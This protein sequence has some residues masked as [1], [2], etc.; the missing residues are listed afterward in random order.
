M[1][2]VGGSPNCTTKSPLL[3]KGNCWIHMLHGLDSSM[4]ACC[5]IPP[6]HH[7]PS[8]GIV[9]MCHGISPRPHMAKAAAEATTAAT[10]EAAAETT[11]PKKSPPTAMAARVGVAWQQL[12]RQGQQ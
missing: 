11:M 7:I 1:V 2:H 3:Q 4:R 8:Q 10:E 6:C 5:F 12:R 9:P